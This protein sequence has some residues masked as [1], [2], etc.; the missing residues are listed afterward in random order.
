MTELHIPTLRRIA[1][2][3]FRETGR[4]NTELL[5]LIIEDW[6]ID[7]AAFKDRE[8]ARELW[9]NLL[10]LYLI[11]RKAYEEVHSYTKFR[12]HDLKNG[13]DIPDIVA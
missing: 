11:D 2:K 1:T 10:T 5:D 6:R 8:T 9:H 7:L 3:Q 12:L 13:D 4:I